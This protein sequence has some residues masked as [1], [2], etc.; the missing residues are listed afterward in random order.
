MPAKRRLHS[1]PE[2]YE[3]LSALN[4]NFEHVLA[5]LKALSQF[6]FRQELLRIFEVKVE[7]LRAWANSELLEKQLEC[8]LREWARFGRQ[9]RKWEK[10]YEDP[11]DVVLE[12]VQRRQF[13]QE[14]DDVT[15]QKAK[16]R[17]SKKYV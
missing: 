13:H 16:R 2:L 3:A 8:E 1:K 4:H 7:E 6:G 11:D 9:S 15:S 10:R 14:N 17:G 12:R 5:D